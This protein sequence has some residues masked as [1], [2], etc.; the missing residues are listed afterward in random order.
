VRQEVA[1]SLMANGYSMSIRQL[2]NTHSMSIAGRAA[3]SLV[4]LV[5]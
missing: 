3:V 2:G 1:T 5:G 4:L